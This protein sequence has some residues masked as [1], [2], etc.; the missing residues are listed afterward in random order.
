MNAVELTSKYL[1]NEIP[2]DEKKTDKFGTKH[3]R[4]V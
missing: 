1:F 3:A 4:L 2:D